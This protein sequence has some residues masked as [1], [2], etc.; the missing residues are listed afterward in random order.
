[1][2]PWCMGCDT[3]IH[4]SVDLVVMDNRS[5]RVLVEKYFMVKSGV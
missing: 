1:M 4:A 2:V 5:A 3:V